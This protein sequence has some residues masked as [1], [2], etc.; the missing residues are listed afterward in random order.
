[1]EVPVIEAENVA[2]GYITKPYGTGG[3]VHVQLL[4]DFPERFK[5]LKAVTL[6]SGKKRL[7]LEVEKAYLSSQGAVVKFKGFDDRNSA[8]S[9]RGMYLV[10]DKKQVKDLAE[11][12]YY[13]FD[14]LGMEVFTS[15]GEFLGTVWDVQKTGGND[16]YWVRNEEKEI[17]IPIPALKKVVK[18]VDISASKMVVELMPGLSDLIV[19]DKKKRKGRRSPRK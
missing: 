3:K 19:P 7:K 18:E 12:S 17:E 5:N 16:I 10:I 4:T 15:K 2:I 8:D 11:N 9:L 6:S 13:I 14:V 1:M